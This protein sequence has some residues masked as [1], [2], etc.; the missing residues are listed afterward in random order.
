M[1]PLSSFPVPHASVSAVAGLA[2]SLL[3]ASTGLRASEGPSHIRRVTVYPGSAWV[4]R[5]VPVP[6][7]AREVV[8]PCLSTHFDIASL[9][10]EG[11][12]QVRL[13]PIT[14]TTQPRANVPACNPPA[15]DTRIQTLEDR[16]ASVDAELAARELVLT[17]LKG[18]V[19]HAGGRG[20]ATALA[21]TLAWVQRTGQELLLQQHRLRR[22]RS[23][24]EQELAPLQAERTRQ[25]HQGEVRQLTIQL[26]SAAASELRLQYLVTGPTWA[27]AYRASLDASGTHIDMERLAQVSQSTGEDWTGVALRLST[28]AP[29]ATTAGPQPRTWLIS[30]RPPAAPLAAEGASM[31]VA[32]APSPRLARALP[33]PL[34]DAT[35]DFTVQITQGEFATIF[36]VPGRSD[37][38]SGDPHVTF[39]LDT[40]RWPAS[41]RVQ[42]VP[43]LDTSAWVVADVARPAGIWPDG[44]LQLVRGSQ[45]VGRSVWRANAS[46]GD[47]VT[48]PFGRDEQ[49]RVQSLPVP[50][51]TTTTGLIGSRAEQRVSHLYEIENRHRTPVNLEVLEASPVSTDAQITVTR[52][53]DPAPQP[54]ELRD[55]PGV[56]TW[57]QTL[58]P[59]AKARFSAQYLISRPK[60]LQV[61]ERR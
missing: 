23:G 48:L 52:Q 22:Q 51:H 13:G 47:M 34:A 4:E 46:Q 26:S 9:R 61:I 50:E 28:G 8:I 3:L 33:A 24:I 25:H 15:L 18:D 31:A 14:A 60:D 45:T 27:P 43:R 17:Q 55:Q 38:R 20:S 19:T 56:V 40:Q 12:A 54:G 42:A 53:W 10:V 37:V 58:A 44:P 11:D 2:L 16:L 35:P 21:A 32:A 36:D 6:A 5:V 1:R 59:T 29:Q 30:P 41:V 39:S 7:G 49:V 57:R